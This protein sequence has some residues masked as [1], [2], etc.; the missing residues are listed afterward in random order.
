MRSILEDLCQ[1][2]LEY[3]R[4]LRNYKHSRNT[5]AINGKNYQVALG[6]IRNQLETEKNG[7]NEKN[8]VVPESDLD[9]FRELSDIA[10]AT[11]KRSHLSLFSN[12]HCG[13]TQLFCRRF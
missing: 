5:I 3:A 7:K 9:F 8:Y 10:S 1:L 11:P 6:S 4:L 2:D 12:P 13:L